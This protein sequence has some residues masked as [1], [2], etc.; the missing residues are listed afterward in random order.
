MRI[1]FLFIIA[2]WSAPLLVFSQ[3]IRITATNAD[4]QVLFGIK[5][6]REAAIQKK[7]RIIE[8]PASQAVIRDAISI[9]IITDSAK[10]AGIIQT[11]K[12]KPAQGFADQCYAIRINKEGEK[13]NIYILS[14]E[15]TGAMYG[16]L[17]IAEAIECNTI[18][19]LTESDNSPYLKKRGIKFNIPLDLRTPSYSDPGDAHQQNISDVW[20]LGFWQTYFDEMAVHRYNVMTWWSLQPFPSMVKVPEFPG[21]ALND[22]WRTKEK[23]NDS[24]SH[25]GLN[26]DQPYLFNKVE[27]VKK[28]TIDEKII[29]W[30]K[31]MQMAA[32]RGIDIYLFTWNM[33]TYGATGK[34]GITRRQDNDTTIAWFRAAVREMIKTYPLLRGIGITSGEGMDNKRT[35]EYANEKWLWK[36]YGEGIRDGL[37]DQLVREFTLVHRFHWASLKEIQ[38]AFKDLPCRLELSLKYAIAHMYSIPDPK[39]ILPAMPLLS[40]QIQSW[41]T[42]R[43]DD[44]YSFRWANNDYARSFI[45]SI[46]ETEKIAGFYMGPDGYCWGRDYLSKL[47]HGKTPPLIIQKQW[48]SFMLWGRLSYN[49]GLPDNLFGRHL[50]RHFPSIDTDELMKGWSAASM[51]FP[52]IT[53]F[54]W[55]DIDLKWFP[56]ANLSHPSHKGFYTVKDYIEREPMQG[57]N[58]QGILSWVNDQLSG[59]NSRLLSPLQVAGILER[60]SDTSLTSLQKMPKADHHSPG[61]LNQTLSDIGGF[62]LIGKYYAEKIRAACDLALLD[63]TR[64]EQYRRSSLQH[65]ELAKKYWNDYAAIYSVKNKVALYNRVGYVDVEKLKENVQ[66][67]IDMVRNWKPGTNKL[68]IS[69]RTETPFKQ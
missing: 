7:W 29:F 63:T 45:K 12:W 8:G 43:N 34:Q 26:F 38:T 13:K 5:K 33:F 25:T 46:P 42:I 40:P 22:V 66:H 49:P 18:S 41:L 59:T 57:S 19:L 47:S 28:I 36:T 39:F 55:G 64:E 23:F 69:D 65:L 1:F 17:D 68:T 44:I 9:E 51:I 30:K 16:A 35:D 21:V 61:E 60:L 67:D 15:T 50:S 11:Y 24:F 53:R 52:W 27:L 31:V 56:E 6:I 37:K 32:D 2:S 58:I 62:A 10:A 48:Y 20:E 14:G 3:E 54:V 4:A